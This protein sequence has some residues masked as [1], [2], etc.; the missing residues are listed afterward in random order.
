MSAK[1]TPELH[2]LRSLVR[3]QTHGGYMWAAVMSDGAVLCVPCIRDN[4]R[5]I[6]RATRDRLRDGWALEGYV[7][8]GESDDECHCDNCGKL[9]W[10][11]QS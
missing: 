3:Y 1:D 8:S 9:T 2:T 6:F 5:Q 7:Y 4:Y 10:E 11:G